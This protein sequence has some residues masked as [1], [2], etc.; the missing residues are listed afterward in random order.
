MVN[1]HPL[2]D[3]CPGG[4]E[5]EQEYP[6]DAVG[7]KCKFKES[8]A[9][10]YVNGSVSISKDETSELHLHN[11]IL[12]VSKFVTHVL[13]LNLLWHQSTNLAK[14][15]FMHVPLRKKCRLIF[16]NSC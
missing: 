1:K 6:Y 3:L 10:V 11:L 12:S 4:L 16:L 15:H 8:E 13:E 14:V 2:F 9:V 7:E 5:T